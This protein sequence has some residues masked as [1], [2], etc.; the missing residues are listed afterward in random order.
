MGVGVV[1]L[2]GVVEALQGGRIHVLEA[3]AGI[4]A[5]D[6]VHGADGQDIRGAG[7]VGVVAAEAL[8]AADGLVG[9]HRDAAV[10]E[11]VEIDVLRVL[12]LGDQEV[13][14]DGVGILLLVEEAL[15]EVL[16]LAAGENAVGAE[17]A[18]GGGAGEGGGAEDGHRA[19]HGEDC[20]GCRAA[21]GGDAADALPELALP[22]RHGG[23]G[24]HGV[25]A[26]H[27]DQGEQGLAVGDALP[28]PQA[29]EGAL[30]AGQLTVAAGGVGGDPDQ[31]IE[32]VDGEAE[33][34]DQA[35]EG[36]QVPGV[37]Q[38]VGQ[39]VALPAFLPGHG[40]G[41][42]DGGAEETGQAGGR[43]ALHRIDRQGAVRPGEGLAAAAQEAGEAEV[44]EDE[45]EGHARRAQ[46]PQGRQGLGG[47]ETDDGGILRPG[48]RHRRYRAGGLCHRGD[49]SRGGRDG[50]DAAIGAGGRLA[51]GG[52]RDGLRRAGSRLPGAKGMGRFHPLRDGAT[53]GLRRGEDAVLG[54][55]EVH[56]QQQ[57]QRDQTP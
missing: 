1:A 57:P 56:R 26:A 34:A 51:A 24:E 48:G 43:D 12:I 41:Q 5:E 11:V 13:I 7:R 45:P 20:H 9:G 37:G 30:V 31:G 18:A 22:R 28:L 21:A 47:G 50:A 32:P 16:D 29:A 17:G 52:G 46:K 55:R 14:P 53:D 33:A 8:P 25:R 19:E 3:L 36:I 2:L 23:G 39:D 15:V 6:G 54:R 42:V 35:P 27:G 40:G 10:E 38:L 49:G 4:L 44:G